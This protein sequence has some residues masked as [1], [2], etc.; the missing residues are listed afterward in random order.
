MTHFEQDT[1]P[2]EKDEEV[3]TP[4]Q[5]KE[6]EIF[7]LKNEFNGQI[8][9]LEEQLLRV[10]ADAE[11]RCRRMEKE[12][13]DRVRYGLAPFAT[14]LLTVA[15]NLDRALESFRRHPNGDQDAEKDPVYLGVEMT[16]KELEKVFQEFHIRKVEALGC[17]FNPEIH[18]AMA[19]K[20]DTALENG[21]VVEVFQNGYMLHE[22]LLRPA[23]VSIAVS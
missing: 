22:R 21:F 23:L 12:A 2:K 7:E 17:A 18:Q 4:G 8:N 16:K 3:K 10:M 9:Q 19:E 1:S 20:R 14:A 6:D 13:A 11:N 5:K 15:D